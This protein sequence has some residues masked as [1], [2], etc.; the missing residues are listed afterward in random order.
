MHF[1]GMLE[2][3][4]LFALF[5]IVASNATKSDAIKWHL[6]LLLGSFSYLWRHFLCYTSPD[7]LLTSKVS[8]VYLRLKVK[9]GQFGLLSEWQN[10]LVHEMELY[11]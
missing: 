1:K 6:Q 7:C 2:A 8:L 11:K 4:T 9:I 3:L 5:V 10:I